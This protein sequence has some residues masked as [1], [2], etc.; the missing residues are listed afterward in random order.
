MDNELI[1]KIAYLIASI[2]FIIGIKMLGKTSTARSGNMLSAV[3]ML[4]AVLV[5]LLDK[6]VLS[7][8]EIF[9]TIIIGSAVGTVV[10]HKVEMT[11]MPE[12][13]AILNGFGGAAS[14]LVAT[15]EYWRQAHNLALIM[16]TI[17]AITV[18]LSVIIGAVTFTGSMVAFGKLKGLINGRAITF[19]GQ[20]L[21]NALLLG[22]IIMLCV[23]I[24]QN[25]N[26]EVWMLAV[27]LI[28]LV[29][30]I[31]VLITICGGVI[32]VVIYIRYS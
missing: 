30:G 21:L 16:D 24:V 29:V 32:P 17:V 13:V 20:H 19:K 26:K 1:I 5:T 28:G 8:Y 12:M 3:A 11:Q 7:F 15:S 25:P 9:I 22:I 18:V 10:A 23:M 27:F 4:I 2:L 6:Q 14:V 31:Q